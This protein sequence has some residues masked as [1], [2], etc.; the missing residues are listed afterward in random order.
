MQIDGD[1]GYI[2]GNDVSGW[3]FGN[4]IYTQATVPYPGGAGV[5]HDN[6]FVGNNLH[7]SATGYD[8]NSSAASCVENNTYRSVWS[9][10]I[11]HDCGGEGFRN[12]GSYTKIVGN[13]IYNNAKTTSIVGNYKRAGIHLALSGNGEPYKSLNVYIDRNTVYD[14]T[15][16]QLY[17]YSDE[18]GI[19]GPVTITG[20]ELSGSTGALNQNSAQGTLYGDAWQTFT[21]TLGCFSGTL[22]SA[23]N[24]MR[25][26]RRPFATDFVLDVAIT[27][28]GT[29]AGYLSATLPV[30]ADPGSNGFDYSAS[31]STGSGLASTI[32]HGSPS[33]LIVK[34]ASDASYPGA[35]ST[36]LTT[37]GTYPTTP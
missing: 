15:S 26:R 2:G 25:Y 10:N 33:T 35:D 19:D 16:T 30:A 28:N 1:H 9:G 8:V 37:Q 6:A 22:S 3:A 5:D 21:S 23:T 13:T 20:N 12:Y 14:T 24:T 4:G 34:K 27:T 31:D 18:S 11:L 36:A 7:D 29:C 17:A 32:S